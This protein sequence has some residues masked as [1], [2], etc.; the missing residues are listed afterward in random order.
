MQLQY[1][2]VEQGIKYFLTRQ[3]STTDASISTNVRYMNRSKSRGR[4]DW[5][6][7]TELCGS[8]MTQ[9]VLQFWYCQCFTS[10]F[11]RKLSYRAPWCPLSLLKK[12]LEIALRTVE[13]PFLDYHTLHIHYR[14]NDFLCESLWIQINLDSFYIFFATLVKIIYITSQR[15]F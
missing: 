15:S 11:V 13:F 4:R 5:Y 10:G 9:N 2:I 7:Y 14:S 1:L 6:T 8:A 12:S 3:P